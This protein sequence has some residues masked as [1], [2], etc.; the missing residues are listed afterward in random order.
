M[1]QGP[2]SPCSSF[3]REGPGCLFIWF[4]F[5]FLLS[6]HAGEGTLE[7][8]TKVREQEP[9][10]VLGIIGWCVGDYWN[11]EVFSFFLSFYLF[12]FFFNLFRKDVGLLFCASLK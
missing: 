1:L 5:F 3:P 2:T 9:G 6:R 7:W 10:G 8:N 4:C 12:S 11:R